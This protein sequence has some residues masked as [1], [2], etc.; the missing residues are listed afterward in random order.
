MLKKYFLGY[1]VAFMAIATL[2]ATCVFGMILPNSFSSTSAATTRLQVQKVQ[3]PD[4][5]SNAEDYDPTELRHV[6][7][8][9]SIVNENDFVI[10]N[11]TPQEYMDD[12]GETFTG[13]EAILVYFPGSRQISTLTIR[14]NDRLIVRNEVSET[15]E[16]S[17]F[18]QYLHALTP[19]QVQ[20]VVDPN[21]ETPY[22]LHPDYMTIYQSY[23]ENGSS[24]VSVPEGKYEVIV[25]Y[26][27]ENTVGTSEDRI[28]FYVTTQDTYSQIN[29][30]PTFYDTEKFDLE[31]QDYATLHYF[32][33]NNIYT[34]IY[35]EQTES[36]TTRTTKDKLYYP[37]VYYNPEKYQLSYTRTLYNYTE[38]VTLNFSAISIGTEETGYLL[39]T[40]STNSGQSNTRQ[41]V[42]RKSGNTF[43][44]KLQ[45]DQPGDYVITKTPV[46]R[47]GISGNQATYIQP[48]GNLISINAS[49]TDLLKPEH[50]VIN[51]YTA[52]YANSSTTT[53]PLYNDTYSYNT[54]ENVTST[55][56]DVVYAHDFLIESND[57][58]TIE[59]F[60]PDRP[61]TTYTADFSFQNESSISTS[62]GIL[63][64]QVSPSTV[65]DVFNFSNQYI[66]KAS[67]NQAPVIFDYYGRLSTGNSQNSPS[68]YAYK[69]T[70]GNVTIQRYT[71][72]LQF[73]NAGEYI[74]YLT[75]ENLVHEAN[76][77]TQN[78]R[79]NQEHHQIFYFE[80]TNTTPELKVYSY[81]RD[82]GDLSAPTLSTDGSILNMDDYTNKY[83]YASWEAAGPFDASISARYSVY[84]WDG[85]LIENKANLPFNGLVYQKSK[86]GGVYDVSQSQPTVLYGDR[87][88]INNIGGTD[89][90]YL[91]QVYKNDSVAYVNYTFAID[92]SP[93][94]GIGAVSVLA[95]TS[96]YTVSHINGEVNYVSQL[97]ESNPSLFNLVSASAFGW[98]WNEKR[99]NAPITARYVYA[100]IS[101]INNF[102]LV[103]TT[104][105]NFIADLNRQAQTGA[106]LMPTN[107]S[108][109]GFT[110][111]I[112]YNKVR[113]DIESLDSR[114]SNS[115]V[116]NTPQLAILLLTDAAGNTAIFA[117]LLDNTNTQVFQY[118]EQSSY[119]NVITKDT[120]FYWGTHKGIAVQDVADTETDP[121][122]QT[123]IDDI[124]DF[125]NSDYVWTLNGY[126]YV[127]NNIIINAFN[128]LGFSNTNKYL[129][130]P[131]EQVD[132]ASNDN[133]DASI[134]PTVVTETDGTQHAENW[135]AIIK[136]ELGAT[137]NDADITRI[138]VDGIDDAENRLNHPDHILDNGE[139]RY[140][141]V[142]WDGIY[143]DNNGGLTI[144]VNL[145]RSLGSLR[146]YNEFYTSYGS[147]LSYDRTDSSSVTNRQYVPN[148]YSTNRRFITF[149]WTEP[150]EYFTIDS[151]RLSFY[152]LSYDTSSPNYP[153]GQQAT[154]VT[155][156]DRNTLPYGTAIS[157]GD[158]FEVT[159]SYDGFY[160]TNVLMR[161]EYSQYFGTSATQEGMF[162]IT[163]TYTDESWNNAADEDYY[164][165]V[166]TKTYTYYVDR[167][168]VIPSDTSLYGSDI[169]LQFGYDKGEYP[170]YPD[171]GSI[172]FDQFSRSSNNDTFSNISFDRTNLRATNPTST[173]ISS[174]ILPAS[175]NLSYWLEEGTNTP[176]Y[177]KYY[178]SAEDLEAAL[179][180][181]F[182]KYEN[183]IE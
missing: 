91:I 96:G 141:L 120:N 113:T 85:N 1:F 15:D 134:T 23:T 73:Q 99:S 41:Y 123:V 151:I 138:V 111:A 38:T 132:F 50:L 102:S 150:T 70:Q 161:I 45:F 183:N 72:G 24:N 175:L 3:L 57:S 62:M 47:T 172:T 173:V 162:V 68:W 107:A 44:I 131:L 167:N 78:G 19:E 109:N 124:F 66:T 51:G 154:T 92:T 143:N 130:I 59:T 125:Q 42:I 48:D 12:R 29:E 168:E 145:D 118:P 14:F 153:Y 95:D 22:T 5:Y 127:A 8:T 160:Q 94:T 84:D 30:N 182:E 110:P 36:Y 100:S 152:A 16:E 49:D 105:E 98:T 177:D 181:I 61:E 126:Q 156:Y 54:M 33:Y 103:T 77:Q 56:P 7:S 142:V 176:I 148:T 140:N 166:Q 157:N 112:E 159:D 81:D 174:N 146:S 87:K 20:E 76:Q 90:Y 139:F 88:T 83:V 137:E 37:Q 28:T 122:T 164:G 53:A 60:A 155:L 117:T 32:N 13:R 129:M 158:L 17:Y 93:I 39:V 25:T 46:L 71:R 178:Y 170:G 147:E 106:V 43:L 108:L 11:T 65:F 101:T 133:N 163:R 165:D 171:Y 80:I 31:N 79:E 34:T 119:V 63:I 67:T 58:I 115:Q 75:Y 35:N 52:M 18:V 64:S 89:G 9:A 116:I 169:N 86:N 149:S 27:D 26:Y 179:N 40:T 135:W 104:A 128:S 21:A 114:L 55:A 2:F 6:E 10:L 180:D 97:D 144:E 4:V 74:V 82:A 69:D 136:V 121:S